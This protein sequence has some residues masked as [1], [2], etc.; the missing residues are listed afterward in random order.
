MAHM[1]IPETGVM[2]GFWSSLLDT[3]LDLI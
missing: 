1:L 2:G 3:L